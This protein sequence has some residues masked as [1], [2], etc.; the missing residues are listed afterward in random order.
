MYTLIYI[1][2]IIQLCS[3][4]YQTNEKD[5]QTTVIVEE[6][7]NKCAIKDLCDKRIRTRD[8]YRGSGYRKYESKRT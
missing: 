8:F 3:I 6:W 5:M 7:S 1:F 4:I 2:S